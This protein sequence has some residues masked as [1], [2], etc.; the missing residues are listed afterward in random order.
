[1]LRGLIFQS[2][3][4]IH[5]MCYTYAYLGEKKKEEDLVSLG[6]ETINSRIPYARDVIYYVVF[7]P[8]LPL[9]PYLHNIPGDK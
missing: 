7:D 8:K 4:L 3:N 2:S 5:E 1:M 9:R 6:S